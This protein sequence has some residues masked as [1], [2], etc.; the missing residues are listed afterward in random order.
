MFPLEYKEVGLLFVVV[1][2]GEEEEN[3]KAPC[4]GRE[5]GEELL[6]EKRFS[7]GGRLQG[8]LFRGLGFPEGA[9]PCED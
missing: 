3:S 6:E 8:E 4:S 7:D 9:S 1:I 5:E 2:G